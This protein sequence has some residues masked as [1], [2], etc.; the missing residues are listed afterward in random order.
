MV[1]PLKTA[2]LPMAG[3]ASRLMP[4]TKAV[5]KALLPVYDKPLLHWALNE[6]RACGIERFIFVVNGGDT[7]ITD[8]LRADEDLV[9]YFRAKKDNAHAAAMVDFLQDLSFFEKRATLVQQHT[10]KGL[11]D[12]VLCAADYVEGMPF[13]VI[14]VDDLI[15]NQQNG[16]LQQMQRAWDANGG[17]WVALQEVA[18][19]DVHRYGI[20]ALHSE[21][22]TSAQGYRAAGLVEKPTIEDAPSRWAVVG[23]YIL[24]F[25]IMTL[26]EQ[27]Q[28]GSGGEVQ[29]TDA[30]ATY[31]KGGG[32]LYGLP[33]KGR[34]FDCGAIDG[35]LA[36]NSHIQGKQ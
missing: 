3:R 6:A 12:A 8:Y 30:L 1:V 23:R 35:L 32:T 16:C 36:A 13:A 18:R 5:N 15:Y 4:L 10:P 9:A 19:T 27:T 25:E 29:L 22:S 20:M 2:V 33:F 34:R 11:G 28:V 21:A 26:L 24:P 17:A 7:S 31:M 14:L